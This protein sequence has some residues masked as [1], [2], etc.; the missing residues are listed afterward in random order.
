VE[1]TARH[2]A[3]WAG[4]KDAQSALPRYVRRLIHDAGSITQIAVPAGDS[5]SHPGWD[6][7]ITSEHGNAWVPQGKSFWE[8]SCEAEAASKA[9]DD[10]NKRTSDSPEDIRKKSTLVIVTARKW[11]RKGRWLVDKQAASEWKEVRVYDA[12]DLEQWLEQTPA[13]KL[14]FGD[15]IGLTGHGVEDV[16]R[17]WNHWAEQTDV[18]ITPEAFFA[19]RESVRD[20]FLDKLRKGLQEGI[21]EPFTIRADSVEEASAFAAAILQGQPHLCS[22]ALIVTDPMGWRFVEQNSSLRIAVAARPEIAERPTH[23]PGTIVIIPYATG[24]MTG[25]FGRTA[26]RENE[27]EIV[28]ERPKIHE[29]EKALV[30]I[31][32]DEGDAKRLSPSTGRSWSVLRRRRALNPSIRRPAWL[33]AKQVSSLSTLCLLGAWSAS[34]SADRS[35]VSELARR[36]YEDIEQDLRHLA[37]LDDAPILEIGD[38]WRAKSPLEL[39]D[40]FGE[41]ITRD[42]IDRFFEIAKRVLAAPDPVLELQEHD[43]YAAQ[44]HGKVRPES[45]LLIRSICDTLV[46]LSVRGPQVPALA[47]AGVEAKVSLFV[48]DLLHNADGA[49]WLSLASLLPDLA[50]AAPEVFLKCIE[51][52][53]GDFDAPVTRLLTETSDS[54]SMGRCWHAGLLWSLE[55]LAWAPQR[56]TRIALL[57]ARLALTEIKGNWA[58][59]PKRTLNDLFRSWLPQTAANLDQRISALEQLIKKEPDIAFDLLDRLVNSG[60]DS[61]TPSARPSWRDDD[62]GAGR[63]VPHSERHGMLVA[64]AD[65]LIACAKGEPRRIAKVMEK[66]RIFDPPRASATLALAEEFTRPEAADDDKEIIRAALRKVIHWQRNYGNLRG[67]ALKNHLGRLEGLYERLLPND[68]IVRYR[69]LF[70]DGQPSIPNGV[71]DNDYTKQAQLVEAARLAALTELYETYGLSGIEQLAACC[72]NLGEIGLCLAKLD[73]PDALILAW[74]IENGDDC[75]GRGPMLT[76]IQG[77]LRASAADRV[78][79]ILNAVLKAARQAHWS[80]EKIARFLTLSNND[81]ETWNTAASLGQEVESAYWN[82]CTPSFWIRDDEGDFDVAVRRLVAAGRP[83]SALQFCSISWTKVDPLLIADML[84][85]LLRGDEPNGPLLDS[86]HI[87]QALDRLEQS[88][89]LERN[90][91]MSIGFR[92]I[93]A[94]GYEG[95]HRAASLYAGLM[96]DPKLFTELLCLVYWPANREHREAIPE[97]SKVAAQIA[98]QVLH[99]CRRQPGSRNDGQIDQEEFVRFIDETRRLCKDADRLVACDSQLG[100]ILAHASPD[101]DGVW[102]PAP[103]RDLLNRPELE[104]M[105]N[106]FAIGA[107]NKRGVTSRAYDEGGSQERELAATFRAHAR[108][109]HNSHV[110]VAATLEQL[111]S[112]YENDGLQEDLQAKLRREDY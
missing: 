11:S 75:S 50:E 31:G 12:D 103:V 40:L 14:R 109:L 97:K 46:K 80:A 27:A 32:L 21:A 6:G 71:P 7:E 111:A 22:T 76:V 24:D 102:P 59:S 99:A 101:I 87:G 58:N 93:P 84:E 33:D 68:P 77:L 74:V 86:Y 8:M 55:R 20:R 1:I 38:V 42:E 79:Q 92:L 69:W 43:R 64:A 105:R 106:S 100:Q 51:V 13:V 5:T 78:H 112:S 52:S 62:A 16:E 70:S 47:A 34:K 91:L 67:A 26:D 28:L 10:Y 94:L 60:P 4:G 41:R 104:E 39:L 53:L 66:I 37:L 49:R 95:E 82:V 81:R 18:K 36:D 90:R 72:S 9:N 3:E 73:V 98:W 44:I 96:S 30:S 63:G 25:R 29:F 17:H 85:G 65:R 89:A 110:Y 88:S 83:R 54:G 2:I 57:L 15:E 56:L 48:R 23:R 45:G 61:A 108:V 107:M 35:I 19:G